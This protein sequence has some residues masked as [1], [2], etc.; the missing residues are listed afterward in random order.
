MRVFSCL[1]E[2]ESII[3][4][5]RLARTLAGRYEL[6]LAFILTDYVLLSLLSATIGGRVVTH[7]VLACTLLVTLLT[8]R[9]PQRLVVLALVVIGVSVLVLVLLGATLTPAL[10]GNVGLTAAFGACVVAVT[11]F[12]IARDII[13]S[14]QVT[15]ES[16]F[17]AMCVYLLIGIL[18]ALLYGLSGAFTPA[19]F[20]GSASLGTASNYLFF[21]FMTLTTVGYGNLIPASAFGQSL[22]MLEAILGQVY[23][24]IL[25]AR[26][27]SLW[28]QYLP[29]RSPHGERSVE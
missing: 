21:S 1:N 27:V 11:P 6:L 7:L 8:A 5:A 22:S 12:V 9:A 14:R 18:F 2:K 25:V 15:T 26:L 24:V 23:V 10:S 13:R 17:G 28:G 20:F 29:T 4:Y 16:V 19:G 3:M